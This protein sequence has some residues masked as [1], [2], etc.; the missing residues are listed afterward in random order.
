MPGIGVLGDVCVCADSPR[1]SDDRM[2]PGRARRRSQP[3][4]GLRRGE[5][6]DV[7]QRRVGC[8]LGDPGCRQCVS[9]RSGRAAVGR[10]VH[11]EQLHPHQQGHHVT[12]R[13]TGGNGSSE[14]QWRDSGRRSRRNRQSA[15][16]GR[17][18]QSLAETE[19]RHVAESRRQRCQRGNVGR[20]RQLRRLCRGPVRAGRCQRVQRRRVDEPA[21][22]AT[23]RPRASQSG[24]PTAPCSC[25]T[26]PPTR[27]STIRFRAR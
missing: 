23:A 26:T 11:G 13:R 18:A 2:A 7:R 5:R 12:R 4:D 27:S 16:R 6:L 9:G 14:D 19:R 8:Q 1:G 22:L 20:G 21:R 15:D 3:H 17:R 24:R 25:G 10:D